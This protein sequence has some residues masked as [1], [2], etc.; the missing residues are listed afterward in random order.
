MSRHR[1]QRNKRWRKTL[2]KVYLNDGA[3]FTVRRRLENT[4]KFP[5]WASPLQRIAALLPSALNWC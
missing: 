3:I 5:S 4:G 1:R 2:S